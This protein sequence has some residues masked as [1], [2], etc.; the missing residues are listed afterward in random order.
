MA[1]NGQMTGMLGVYLVAAELSR[2]NFIVS[3]T[4]RGAAGA[5][6]L[7]T[8]QAC[9]KAWSV[10]VK[11]NRRPSNTWLVGAHARQMKSDSHVYVFVN[12]KEIENQRPDY[13]VTASSW[14]A[15]HVQDKTR[16]TGSRW[17]WFDKK[18]RPSPDEGWEI[19]GNPY[20]LALDASE[21]EVSE[22][23]D[24]YKMNEIF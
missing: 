16:T 9:T 14:V 1:S 13:F 24:I 22:A 6:L 2:R 3:P 18:D 10:Q 23:N 20:T 15:S 7:V 19:F 17:Y 11:T 12:L 4:S 8:D 5:D 21:V